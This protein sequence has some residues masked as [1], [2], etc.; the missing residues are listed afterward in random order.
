MNLRKLLILGIPTL[1]VILS[2]GISKFLESQKV[3]PQ[4]KGVKPTVLNVFVDSLKTRDKQIHIEAYGKVVA[5][6][7]INLVVEAQGKLMK[8]SIDLKEGVTF[9]KGDIL[10]QIDI[11]E[12]SNS[13]QSQRAEFIQLLAS[14][15]PELKIDFP[16]D[17]NAIES[18]FNQL[19]IENALP[20]FPKNI[21]N[22]AVLFLTTRKIKNLYFNI[23]SQQESLDKFQFVAPF[24]GVITQLNI[25][26]GSV[27]NTGMN[28][29]RIIR[30]DVYELE[31]M[32]SRFDASFVSKGDSVLLISEAGIDYFATIERIGGSIDANSQ[33]L[34]VF[35]K[36]IQQGQPTIFENLY[37]KGIISGKKLSNIQVLPREAVFNFDEIF[38]VENNLLK[39]QKV[40]ILHVEKDSVII[41]P[42]SENISVVFESLSNAEEGN[43][44]SIIHSK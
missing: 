34:Q 27:V 28:V 14:T 20:D 12:I 2:F 22:K 43:A 29:G 1:I 25:Q 38:Y 35:C 36:I 4:K 11:D 42:L 6:E 24:S 5:S 37:L 15:L 32:V 26:F 17:Y 21:S 41:S 7:S 31:L 13:I 19:K 9:K 16:Q 39:K 18:Y 3:E 10:F 44:V 30:N 8:G 23:K 40:K 33:S